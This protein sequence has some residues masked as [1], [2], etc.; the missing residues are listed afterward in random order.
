M[1][2]YIW[3]RG[4]LQLAVPD[5]AVTYTGRFYKLVSDVRR[6]FC[7]TWMSSR[8]SHRIFLTF[9]QSRSPLRSLMKLKNLRH[10]SREHI[11][12]DDKPR[13]IKFTCMAEVRRRK[14]CQSNL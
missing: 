8:L 6:C 11:T 3:E 4:L 13:A 1:G 7:F 10:D 12:S 9:I 14:T 5:V 2:E